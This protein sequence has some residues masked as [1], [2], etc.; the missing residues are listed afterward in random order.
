MEV[1][2]EARTCANRLVG[3]P[4][5]VLVGTA[6]VGLGHP[7]GGLRGGSLRSEWWLVEKSKIDFWE[8]LRLFQ[9]NFSEFF[10][11]RGGQDGQGHC[12]RPG[13]PSHVGCGH[14]KR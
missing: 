9:K 5:P 2:D 7:G 12:H 1:S 8:T 11:R 3:R 14:A 6:Q 13:D 10:F 4:P